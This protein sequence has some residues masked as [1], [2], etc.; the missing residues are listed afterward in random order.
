MNN[1]KTG[2]RPEGMGEWKWYA[3]FSDEVFE[4]ECDTREEAVYYAQ[5]E[6]REAG[7]YIVEARKEPLS[8][9]KYFDA[10]NFLAHAE[11]A[12]YD[13]ASE[14]GSPLFEVSVYQRTDLEQAVRAAFTEWQR[15]NKLV[16]MPWRFTNQRNDEFISANSE[17]FSKLSKEETDRDEQR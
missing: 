5:N 11:D 9:A 6:C 10:D 14:D 12:A 2:G 15:R 1:D 13:Y 8:L 16:F 4:Y 17:G 7:G 3:G